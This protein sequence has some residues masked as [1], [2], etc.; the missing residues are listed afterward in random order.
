MPDMKQ[1]KTTS[2]RLLPPCNFSTD[3]GRFFEVYN[4]YFCL[5]ETRTLGLSSREVNCTCK[6]VSKVSL[7]V[8]FNRMGEINC[9]R[10]FRPWLH[11]DFI[12]KM[13]PIGKRHDECLEVLHGF[14]R[15][16]Q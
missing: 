5:A 9:Y 16:V 7:S 13:L 12:F 8:S 2:P 14:T 11:S 15:K 10:H 4:F 1:T 3:N 6:K